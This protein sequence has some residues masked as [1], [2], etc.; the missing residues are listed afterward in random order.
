MGKLEKSFVLIFSE[1]NL[2]IKIRMTTKIFLLIIFGLQTSGWWSP[3]SVR[4]T[5]NSEIKFQEQT[6]YSEVIPLERNINYST[7][8]I[9]KIEENQ[10]QT[11]IQQKNTFLFLVGMSCFFLLFLSYILLVQYR[12]KRY[13]ILSE[14]QLKNL[15]TETEHQN[16]IQQQHVQ[17]LG[18]LYKNI[19]DR[20]NFVA[21]SIDKLYFSTKDKN[22]LASEKISEINTFTQN[23]IT[24]FR[25][26]IWAMRNLI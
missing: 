11:Q 20:L 1:L 3:V 4:A 22:S 5:N 14:I 6:L 17:M 21:T 25:D 8:L 12:Q 13:T 7:D 9:H 16:K 23:T 19:N 15:V 18:E 2:F 24:Q 10:I 26:T